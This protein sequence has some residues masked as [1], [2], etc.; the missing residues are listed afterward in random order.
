MRKDMDDLQF[1]VHFFNDREYLL[2]TITMAGVAQMDEICE[3][4][5][6]QRGWY[7]PRF[8]K[9]ERQAYLE[10]RRFVE[11]ELYEGFTRE[12]GSLKEKAPV[13]FYLIPGITKQKAIERARRRT[14][15]DETEP[16]VLM[17]RI[18]DIE[19]TRNMTFTLSDSH[20]AYRKKATE[21]GI[22]CRG[23]ADVNTVLADHNQVFP[24][25]MIEQLHR[26]YRAQAIYYEVQIWDYDLLEGMGYTILG[27]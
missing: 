21:S 18:Q 23:D 16:R 26:K 19:D 8:A 27:E 24:F 14:D 6:S 15:H 2:K 3:A 11:N 22:N 13:Y 4:I 12:Y 5:S 25:A 20:I 17:V 9:S 1:L 10:R 7:W